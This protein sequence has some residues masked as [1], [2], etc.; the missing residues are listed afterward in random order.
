MMQF[1][2]QLLLAEAPSPRQLATRFAAGGGHLLLI[3]I[4]AEATSVLHV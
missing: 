2:A 3:G 1:L 4:G